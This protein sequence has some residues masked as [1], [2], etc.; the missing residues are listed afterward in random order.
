MKKVC[1]SA[2]LLTIALS[3][4]SAPA[5]AG[6]PLQ[7]A[8]GKKHVVKIPA[9]ELTRIAIDGGRLQNL[10]YLKDELEVNEDKAAG[11]VYVRP[12]TSEKQISVF[13]TS[14]S[15]A[16]HELVLQPIDSMPLESI[17]IKDPP[18]KRAKE[19]KTLAERASSMDVA[20]K[21]L[22]LAMARGEK[23]SQEASFE[24]FNIPL[25]LWNEARFVLVGKYRGFG[26]TG[27]S[28]KLT[29]V[30]NS[31]MKLAEQ[32]FYKPGV[33]A[34]SVDQMILK[35]SESTDVFVIKVGRDD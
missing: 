33:L 4:F 21:R 8:E 2:L 28:Y 3:S 14:A 35:P 22:I 29:N 32:E 16:T 18:S 13:V 9:R 25:G 17:L 24:R 15:G 26:M 7:G 27:E 11:V 5:F 19:G 31:V 6:E 30:S 12:L 1:L 23:D 20:V 34:V 10:R